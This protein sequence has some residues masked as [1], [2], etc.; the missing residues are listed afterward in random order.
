MW[1]VTYLQIMY[2][3]IS[4]HEI[5]NEFLFSSSAGTIYYIEIWHRRLNIIY[6]ID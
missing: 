1:Y 6:M 5:Y 4:G 3:K 2:L